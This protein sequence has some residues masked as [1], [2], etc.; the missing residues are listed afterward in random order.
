MTYTVEMKSSGLAY[1]MW[2]WLII[3]IGKRGEWDWT[4]NDCDIIVSFQSEIDA[5]AFKLRWL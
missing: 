1:P 4:R 3:N 5:M 2:E